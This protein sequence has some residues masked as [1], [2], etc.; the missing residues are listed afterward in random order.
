MALLLPLFHHAG[1]DTGAYTLQN[2]VAFQR[3]FSL[4]ENVSYSA[5]GF[6]LGNPWNGIAY[7]CLQSTFKMKTHFGLLFASNS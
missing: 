1:D 7:K 4:L 3:F 2:R 6:F 5:R